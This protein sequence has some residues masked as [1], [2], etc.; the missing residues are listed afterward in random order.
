METIIITLDNGKKKE[1]VKGIKLKE[2]ISNLKEEYPEPIISAKYNSKIICEEEPLLKNG[3]LSLYDINTNQG[4]KIYERGLLY[5][6]EHCALDVLGKDTKIVVKHSIDKGIYCKIDKDITSEDVTK[7]KKVMK[8]KV[9][10]ALP[11]NKLKHQK[12]ML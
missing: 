10:K 3:T 5:L 11:F 9:S 6:F 12:Q 1:Y 2:V 8:E 4:N 7:I